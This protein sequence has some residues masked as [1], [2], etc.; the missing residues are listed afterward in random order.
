MPDTTTQLGNN[1]M[2]E[3]QIILFKQ[4]IPGFEKRT[5]FALIE[6]E[7]TPFSY[8]QSS[9]EEELIFLTVDPFLFY[10][11]YEFD[12]PQSAMEDLQV[13]TLDQVVVRCLVTVKEQLETATMNLV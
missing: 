7:D 11:E 9:E 10:P 5:Q 12:I 3:H 2:D 8:L 4:G 13:N 1:E 6:V